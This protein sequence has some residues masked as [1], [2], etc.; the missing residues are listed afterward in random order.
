MKQD[1]LQ[2]LKE[3]AVRFVITRETPGKPLGHFNQCQHAVVKDELSALSVALELRKLLGLPFTASETSYIHQRMIG[4]QNPDTG[5]LADPSWK[6]RL[7]EDGMQTLTDGDSF[8]TRCG[9]CALWAWGLE[10]PGPIAEYLDVKPEDLTARIAWGRG[11]HHPFSLGDLAVLLQHNLKLGS[12]GAEELHRAFLRAVTDKQ[13]SVTGLW[14]NGHPGE[15]LTPSINHSFHTVKFTF[16][17]QNQPLPFAEQAI[18][19]C[20]TACRDDR[21]YSW[22]NGFACNDLDL[23]LMFYTASFDTNYRRQDIQDW[24]RERLPLILEVQKPDGGFSFYHERAMAQHGFITVSSGEAEGDLWGTLMYL[25]TIRMMVRLGYPELD[26]PWGI[27]R[28]HHV[29]S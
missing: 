4:M 22:E 7:R 6:G 29:R 2:K 25:G 24:A 8:F 28:V 5:L 16:N 11:G 27:S 15:A 21:F 12:P 18:D 20:L 1:T 9:I 3:D 13:D 26:V 23:A 17:L 14:M 10:L 19:S